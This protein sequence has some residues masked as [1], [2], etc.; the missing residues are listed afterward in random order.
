[1]QFIKKTENYFSV[2][3]I[4]KTPIMQAFKHMNATA[5]SGSALI[6]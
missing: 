4:Q 3:L 2:F 6:S 1:M 5:L